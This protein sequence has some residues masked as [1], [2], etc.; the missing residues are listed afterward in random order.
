MLKSNLIDKSPP[1]G[2]LARTLSWDNSYTENTSP[3]PLKTRTAN[4]CHEEEEEEDELEWLI[5]IRTLLSSAG[6]EGKDPSDSSTQNWYS[7]Q[8]PLDPSLRDKS[9]AL[10]DKDALPEAKQKQKGLNRKLMFDYM[11]ALIIEM[12]DTRT[13][14]G[15]I[16]AEWVWGQMKGWFTKEAGEG[17][18]GLDSLVVRNEV[19]GTWWVES[20]RLEVDRLE[21]EIEGKLLQELVDEA[22]SDLSGTA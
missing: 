1:I 5:F 22:V 11:S 7:P 21:L 16:S 14:E 2:S 12:T 8:S 13:H 19:V 20:L 9:A 17:G 4:L 18:G 6:L 15:T 10:D 3:Y